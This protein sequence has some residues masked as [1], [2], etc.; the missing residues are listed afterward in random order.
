MSGLQAQVQE[1]PID[2]V[3]WSFGISILYLVSY[4]TYARSPVPTKRRVP[5]LHTLHGL[6]VKPSFNSFCLIIRA[7][8]MYVRVCINCA[9]IMWRHK[10]LRGSLESLRSLN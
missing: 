6:N 8:Q 3:S 2:K 1:V 5:L 9:K 4:I 10:R 7:T